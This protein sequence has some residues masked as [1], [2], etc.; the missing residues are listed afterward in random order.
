MSGESEYVPPEV[1]AIQAGRDIPKPRGGEPGP[2]TI[3]AKAEIGPDIDALLARMIDADE[4]Y[5]M[6]MMPW[7]C[8]RRLIEIQRER[9][10]AGRPPPPKVVRYF[11]PPR[12][13]ART[14]DTMGP[15]V[16]R[17][18]AGLFGL[19]N[20]VTPSREESDNRDRLLMYL[21]RSDG[22]GCII[23]VR[24]RGAVHA[25]SL[26]YLPVTKYPAVGVLTVADYSAEETEKAYRHAL[27]DLI[28]NGKPWQIRQVR[29]AGPADEAPP[30]E[31]FT[32][33]IS[34]ITSHRLVQPSET[35]P[36]VVIAVCGLTSKGRVVVLKKRDR[37]NSID[38]FE[39]LSL[40]SEH[41]IVGD[42]GDWLKNRPALSTDDDEALEQIWA[43]AGRPTHLVL[44]EQF[45]KAAAQRELFLSCGLNVDF[46]RLRFCGYRSADRENGTHLGFAVFRL[47]LI[48]RDDIDELEIIRG[49]SA[50]MT[51][52]PIAQLYQPPN[53]GHLNRL[54]RLERDWLLRDV[55]APPRP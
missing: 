32:G 21:Y 22:G 51:A 49:W 27:D 36:A 10:E 46:D 38:D 25:S 5:I 18:T 29:C 50:D 20:W 9:T 16:Q 1:H 39:R 48:Q 26:N 44:Q 52:I 15:R 55:L 19:R 34:R 23:V 47:D 45:F 13:E 30:G 4:I 28:P 33:R 12:D 24:R 2:A 14:G 7:E 53:A 8:S 40:V 17:W 42:L 54:L 37:Y 31:Q 41:V 35:E 3:P 43:A 6:G 11:S